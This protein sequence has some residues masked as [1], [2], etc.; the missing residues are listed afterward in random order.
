M[1][2][3]S[4][5]GEIKIGGQ[6]VNEVD[7]A[8]LRGHVGVVSQQPNLFDATIV[9]NIRYG[10]SSAASSYNAISDTDVR[11]VAK[12]ANIHSFIMGLRVYHKDTIQELARTLR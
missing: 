12:A 7:V 4:S 8:W 10:A 2:L 1:N 3:V 11:K 5:R 9:E 6:D